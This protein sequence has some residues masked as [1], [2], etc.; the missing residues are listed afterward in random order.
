MI[1]VVCDDVIRLKRDFIQCAQEQQLSDVARSSFRARNETIQSENEIDTPLILTLPFKATNQFN[2]LEKQLERAN[3]TFCQTLWKYGMM[4]GRVLESMCSNSLDLGFTTMIPGEPLNWRTVFYSGLR[5]S[6][7]D[8]FASSSTSISM[9]RPKQ[10]FP[11]DTMFTDPIATRIVNMGTN[12]RHSTLGKAPPQR[13][14]LFDHAVPRNILIMSRAGPISPQDVLPMSALLPP[15]SPRYLV[16][17]Q[18]GLESA[19]V[20]S[21]MFHKSFRYEDLLSSASGKDS[22]DSLSSSNA[23]QGSIKDIMSP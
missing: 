2:E 11:Q 3:S 9:M 7:V 6:L 15:I 10:T 1:L 19:G 16:T 5:A 17:I 18:Q 13:L 22:N 14:G 23:A 8:L 12:T 4:N 21:P 20:S